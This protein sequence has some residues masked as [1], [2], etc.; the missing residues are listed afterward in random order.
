HE[1]AK[2]HAKGRDPEFA[3]TD[4][5]ALAARMPRLGFAPVA[6]ERMQP[7][8]LRLEGG[9]YCSV[10]G[11]I[12]AQLALTDTSGRRYTLYQWRDHTEFDGLGKAM[13][14]VGDAQVTL[15]REAGLLHGLAGPRR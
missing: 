12:A 3:T 7:A 5:A 14:N 1:I 8:G 11:A 6:P 13:F 9:R 10:G 4:Y 2:N 15:W